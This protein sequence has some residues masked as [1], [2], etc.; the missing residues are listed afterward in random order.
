MHLIPRFVPLLL[1][2]GSAQTGVYLCLRAIYLPRPE[3][4]RARG[5]LA[6]ALWAG[7]GVFVAYLAAA[8]AGVSLAPWQRWLIIYPVLSWYIFSFPLVILLGAAIS[9]ARRL[10]RRGQR[11]PPPQT[12]EH[13]A[14]EHGANEHGA[15]EHGANEHGAN[16]HGA[17]H[18]AALDRDVPAPLLVSEAR[19]R[20]AEPRRIF[21]ARAATGLLGGAGLLA[22][23]G[24]LEQERA[25]ELT[26]HQIF[27]D[28]LHPDLDG[29][30]L[31]QLSDIH[32]GPLIT[33]ER[34]ARF[35]RQA[36]ALSADVV[37]LTGDLL[38]ISARAAEPFARGFAGLRGKLGTFAVLGNHDYYAGVGAAIDAVRAIGGT[39]LRNQGAR[40]ERGQGSLYLGGVDDPMGW[41]AGLGNVDP[42]AALRGAARGEPRIML[43]H[44]P[45]LFALCAAAGA[46]WVLSGHTHGGQLAF[47]PRF[48]MAR[49]I[50]PYT[51]GAYRRGRAQLYVH[52][53]MGVVAGAP[54]RLGSPPELALFTLRRP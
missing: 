53:G 13:G 34:M 6:A 27:L 8:R 35:S 38:D 33:E 3:Q 54:I 23:A 7:G 49:L 22:A 41:D 19:A 11:P 4:R 12:P 5:A 43:A 29:L 30:T 20:I 46:Q 52:R 21:L 10:P 17:N 39:L 2:I 24:V 31:L 47:S 48:S 25:P 40:I 44:R 32:A 14:H 37:V 28:G 18:R 36:A 1:L 50:T 51:M 16:E 15:N 45:Q 26:R 9:V 42:Q